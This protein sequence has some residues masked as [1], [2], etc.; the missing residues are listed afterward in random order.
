MILEN[1]SDYRHFDN[2]KLSIAN[3]NCRCNQGYALDQHGVTCVN[4]DECSIMT[5]VC[6]NGT[7]IDIPG[8]FTCNCDSGFEITPMMQ[9]CMDI[10]ECQRTV[11]LCR[12]GRCINNP[13]KADLLIY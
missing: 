11:G 12:G 10:N 13:G 1:S 5:G 7:C 2:D 8:S 9:V 6:G 4:I 3:T